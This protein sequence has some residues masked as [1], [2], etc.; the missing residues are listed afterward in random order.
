[1]HNY[2]RRKLQNFP[3]STRNANLQLHESVPRSI[4]CCRKATTKRQPIEFV[5]TFTIKSNRELRLT[6]L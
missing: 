6:A 4:S 2:R 1:M 3:T 5:V